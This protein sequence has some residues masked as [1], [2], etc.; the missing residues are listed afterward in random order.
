MAAPNDHPVL[1]AMRPLLPGM[2]R[3]MAKC[4]AAL[5]DEQIAEGVQKAELALIRMLAE[6]ELRNVPLQQVVDESRPA[7]DKH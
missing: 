3:A 4:G 5:T 1:V 6:S 7:C 2:V